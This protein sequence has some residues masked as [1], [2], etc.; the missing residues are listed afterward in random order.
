MFVLVVWVSELDFC[1]ASMSVIS[2]NTNFTINKDL[3]LPSGRA[4][5]HLQLNI[6]SSF[7]SKSL[8]LRSAELLSG[9]DYDS[10]PNVRKS[11]RLCTVDQV[12]FKDIMHATLP[13]I[14]EHDETD[15]NKL[16]TDFE[17]IM[18]NTSLASF[19]RD[20]KM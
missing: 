5:V 3:E 16:L 8:V 12:L 10:I 11:I 17:N 1:L 18:Y 13:P 6:G 15:I 9:Y 4:I 20:T 2:S 7:D 19:K 14:I